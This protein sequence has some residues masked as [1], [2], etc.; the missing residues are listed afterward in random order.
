MARRTVR[1]DFT[2]EYARRYWTKSGH[3][4]RF[5]GVT[6]A[7]FALLRE[8]VL[9]T[10]RATQGTMEDRDRAMVAIVLPETPQPQPAYPQIHPIFPAHL[11]NNIHALAPPVSRLTLTGCFTP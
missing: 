9:Q 10:V 7:W 8:W 6:R 11:R 4:A 5:P 2:E 1:I 3:H